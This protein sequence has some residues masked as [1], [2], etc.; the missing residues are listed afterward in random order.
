L[1]DAVAS[2]VGLRHRIHFEGQAAMELEFEIEGNRTDE[3]YSFCILDSGSSVALHQPPMVIDWEPI[4]LEILNEVERGVSAGMI[5]A[6]FHNTLTEMMVDIVKRIGVER[7]VL[8]GGCFQNRYLT[9]RT[10]NRLEAEGFHPYW[11]QRVPPNDGGI[12]LGQVFAALRATRGETQRVTGY[13]VQET[14]GALRAEPVAPF[15]DP[16][17]ESKDR[18]DSTLS[19]VPCTSNLGGRPCA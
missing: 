13:R 14:S 9:E 6:K 15:R 7:I 1:F 10:V 2:I 4:L 11:H 16:W 5:S 3:A 8:T 18:R 17:A 19:P 12:A